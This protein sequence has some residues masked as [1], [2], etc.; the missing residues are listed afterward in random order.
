M[1]AALRLPPRGFLSAAEVHGHTAILDAFADFRDC[2]IGRATMRHRIARACEYFAPR[3]CV[4]GAVLVTKTEIGMK[5]ISCG[6]CGFQ[7][8][9]VA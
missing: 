8:K 7:T 5:W 9:E 4:C 6:E 2:V 1:T 3:C